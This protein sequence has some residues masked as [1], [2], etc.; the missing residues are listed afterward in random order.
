MQCK[1]ARFQKARHAFDKTVGIDTCLDL[2]ESTPH[3]FSIVITL[4]SLNIYL[5]NVGEKSDIRCGMLLYIIILLEQVGHLFDLKSQLWRNTKFQQKFREFFKFIFL[6]TIP[7]ISLNQCFS[8]DIG[9][10]VILVTVCMPFLYICPIVRTL[11]TREY[12]YSMVMKLCIVMNVL[13]SI[14]TTLLGILASIA[15][16]TTWIAKFVNDPTCIYYTRTATAVLVYMTLIAVAIPKPCEHYY[17]NDRCDFD[18]K[19]PKMP[20]I[21][22]FTPKQ[23]TMS[24]NCFHRCCRH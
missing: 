17:Y 22:F 18:V 8:S 3:I 20:R 1:R 11:F 7:V 15:V 5:R 2:K 10:P 16:V 21:N 23:I 13:I 14:R 4:V 9:I 6:T 24:P 19:W 12:H